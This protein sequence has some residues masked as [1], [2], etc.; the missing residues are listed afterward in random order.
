MKLTEYEK[1]NAE[2]Y[3]YKLIVERLKKRIEEIRNVKRF[4][5][6]GLQMEQELQEIL[7]GEK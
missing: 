4:T 7:E 3:K 5:L 6:S 1:I 2:R